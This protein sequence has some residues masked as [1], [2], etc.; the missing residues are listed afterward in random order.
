MKG[1]NTMLGIL[2]AIFVF[3]IAS[4]Q[5]TKILLYGKELPLLPGILSIRS[6]EELNTGMAWGLLGGKTG[7]VVILSV[8]TVVTL[9]VIV[10]ILVKYRRI[11]PALVKIPL[12]MIAGGAVGNLIDRIALGGVRD[13][14][15]TDFIDFPIFNVADCFVTCGGIL[16]GVALIFTR[17]GR[18]FMQEFFAED[19]KKRKKAAAA[20]SEGEHTDA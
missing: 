16:L 17:P 19:D 9:A 20:A 6:P 10:F 18:R 7:S 15:C 11:M 13:F 2:I 12:A 1:G 14:I 4:D 3:A 8:F 5:A